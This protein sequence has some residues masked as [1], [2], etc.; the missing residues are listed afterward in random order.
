MVEEALG[1][2]LQRQLLHQVCVKCLQVPCMNSFSLCSELL[3]YF[4]Q[5]LTP[6]GT[7]TTRPFSLTI[8]S[9]AEQKSSRQDSPLSRCFL[10]QLHMQQA[11][12]S[13]NPYHDN[14]E[15]AQSQHP[16]RALRR[17]GAQA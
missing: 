7:D 16:L 17:R 13:V 11:C 15:Q 12:A 9:R 4:H 14:S 1:T 8:N 3:Q 5:L 10:V 2:C 6:L